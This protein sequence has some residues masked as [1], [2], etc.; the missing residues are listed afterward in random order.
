[1]ID[2]LRSGLLQTIGSLCADRYRALFEQ[3]RSELGYADYLGARQRSRVETMCNATLDSN[4]LQLS[5][6]LID[7][8]FAE[9]LYPG[10]LC[11]IKHLRRF[12]PTAI[13]SDG[14]VVF[15][16]R[17]VQRSGLWQAVEGRVMIYI[18][19][20]RMLCAMQQRFPSQLYVMVDDKLRLLSAMKRTLGDR[21]TTVFERQ[22]HYAFDPHHN[23]NYP[24]VDIT[25]K[26]IGDLAHTDPPELLGQRPALAGSRDI[27]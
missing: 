23:A 19:K 2:N 12:G 4:L 8:P 14:H 1:M 27:P 17:K 22:G 15:Q 6:Y 20:E 16:P 18:H 26:R 5:N 24:P 25:L 13:L 11:T 10:A 3:I 7:Y 21:I 9:R